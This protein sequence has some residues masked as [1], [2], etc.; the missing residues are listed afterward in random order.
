MNTVI[1]QE[2]H[3][4]VINISP[5]ARSLDMCWPWLHLLHAALQT[6][7]PFDVHCCHKGTAI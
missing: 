4:Q 7:E 6:L 2:T 5:L 1:M 3:A